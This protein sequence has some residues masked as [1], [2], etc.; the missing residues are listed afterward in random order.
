MRTACP[1]G[2]VLRS[3]S[4]VLFAI[5]GLEHKARRPHARSW[6]GLAVIFL[7]LAI[8]ETVQFH[9]LVSDVL[10]ETFN[11]SGFFY[12]AWVVPAAVFV[13]VLA[14]VYL[15]FLLRL[16]VRTRYLMLAAGDLFLSGALG[17]EAV[18]ARYVEANGFANLTYAALSTVEEFLEMV[19]A[20]L[21][22]YAL[23]AY[24]NRSVQAMTLEFGDGK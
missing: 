24:L 12:F 7:L 9:E 20:S 21:F 6:S 2:T 16:P 11:L 23:I 3:S 13:L 15:R 10:E 1:A 22:L 18:T 8:D 14:G 19:G 4:C 17:V 5:A